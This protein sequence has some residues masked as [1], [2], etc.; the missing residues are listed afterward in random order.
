[1][2]GFSSQKNIDPKYIQNNSS[3]SKVIPSEIV[4][5]NNSIISHKRNMS[6]IINSKN[7]N[8]KT[9]GK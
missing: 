5:V 1:M 7:Y 4:Q 3:S 6:I 8:C 9:C 2:K